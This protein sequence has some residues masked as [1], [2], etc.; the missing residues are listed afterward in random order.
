MSFISFEFLLFVLVLV[1]LYF[2]VPRKHQW[3]VL[4][5]ANFVFYTAAGVRM[6]LYIIFTIITTYF[7]ALCL[8]NVNLNSKARLSVGE[9]SLDEKQEIK[10]K[11]TAY[12]KSLCSIA[13][14]SNFGIWAFLKYANFFI[15]NINA[16]LETVHISYECESL[17]LILP[18]GISFYT[19]QAAGY[20]IDIYRGKYAA[21]KNI[22]RFALFLS[23]FPHIIQGPFSRFD[24]LTK[25]LFEEHKF[26]Y[27][28][29]CEGCS[30]ILWGVFK[31]L[32]VADKIAIAVNAVFADPASYGGIYIFAVTIFYG[33]QIY[34]DFSGYMDIACGISHI[35]GINLAEN[36]NQPYFAKSVDEFWRRWHITLGRW[37]RD[38]LF[39]PISMGKFA[40]KLGK[41]SRKK[42][43]A[44]AGKLIPGYFALIFVWSATGLWHGANWTYF[45]WGMLNLVVI[46]A[47]MHLENFYAG[48][49][50]KLHI[51]NEKSWWKT[52][53]MIRTFLIVCLFRFFSR[54]ENIQTAVLMYKNMI[55]KWDFTQMLQPRGWFVE[56]ARKDIL[57]FAMGVVMMFIVDALRENGKWEATKQKT[58]FVIRNAV[59]VILIYSMVLFVGGSNDLI[60]G[61]LYAQF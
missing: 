4:L 43:G 29:L 14:V 9:L 26:S 48:V 58:P 17:S 16:L 5:L 57:I 42:F 36:F 28:H 30:R 15:E 7:A 24:E 6:A 27:D 38:Y 8:E 56:M 1:A 33:I 49:R 46:I 34:A 54:A 25:T 32:I 59:Y 22:F 45:V 60:G 41:K 20:L 31:K 3:K 37:F 2:V 11:S 35:L 47:G 55:L 53:Q 51:D 19:F 21:E 40:Q 52:F 13:L 10:A 23:Y 39:Y 12:K 61:F 18:L 50:E 44:R